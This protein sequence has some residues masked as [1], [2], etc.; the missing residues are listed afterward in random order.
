[1]TGQDFEGAPDGHGYRFAIIVSR[2][3]ELVTDRLLDGAR[4]CLLEHGVRA[5]DVDVVRVPGAFELPAAAAAVLRR[6]GYDGLVV[7]GCVIRGETPHFDYVAGEASRGIQDL[8]VAHPVGVGFGVLTTDTSE[9]AVA[10]AGGDRGNKGWEA[11]LTALEMA[12]LI[13]RLGD[14]EGA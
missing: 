11:A 13:R 10:R 4:G 5:A 9:Q 2:F 14:R 12:D 6:G 3:N 1:M 7:L 8:A